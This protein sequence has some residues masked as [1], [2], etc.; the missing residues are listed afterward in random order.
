MRLRLAGL[1]EPWMGISEMAEECRH[2]KRYRSCEHCPHAARGSCH[3]PQYH[4]ELGWGLAEDDG[5]GWDA[6]FARVERQVERGDRTLDVF[7]L[8]ERVHEAYD[9]GWPEPE[10]LDEETAEEKARAAEQR[11]CREFRVIRQMEVVEAVRQALEG[12]RV[13]T[14]WQ[15]V[16]R[17]VRGIA[18]HLHASKT[19]VYKALVSEKSLFRSVG[20]HSGVYELVPPP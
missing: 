7:T 20:S 10:F 9:Y 11:Y 15:L 17:I 3:Q 6:F 18:P 16:W 4:V 5:A 8:L 14:H 2:F 1:A 12:Q 19:E 13:P